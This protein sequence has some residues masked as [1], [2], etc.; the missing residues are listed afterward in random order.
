MTDT[1]LA[2][3]SDPNGTGPR[4]YHP[5]LANRAM[6]KRA[7]LTVFGSIPRR[8]M[9]SRKDFIDQSRAG[10]PGAW[11]KDVIDQT[12]LR[13]VFLS[14]LGVTSGNLSRV[15]RRKTLDK[16][17]SEEVL[18]TV[19]VIDLAVQVWESQELA[20]EWLN[21]PVVALGG[22]YPRNLFDT[23]EGRRW[24]SQVLNKIEHGDFS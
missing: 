5:N 23:F 11:V 20:L 10:I 17:V 1:T 16:D 15:Y 8:L 13:G 12:G 4:A 14:I 6:G 21:A 3:Q 7:D 24:V 2:I 22:E 18:D 9:E 19:R